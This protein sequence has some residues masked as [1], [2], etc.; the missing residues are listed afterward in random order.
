MNTKYFLILLWVM[1]LA[2]SVSAQ[3]TAFTYQG[4][5]TDG[6]AAASGTYDF[7]FK[8]YSTVN[9]G[10]ALGTVTVDDV[11]VTNGVFTVQLDFGATPFAN[12]AAQFLEICVRL[13]SQT[14]GYTTLTPRQRVN[15]TPYA[16]RSL[17]ANDAL[18]LNGVAASQYVQT[19]D[20]RLSDARPPTAGSAN[21]IQNTTTA[22]AASNFN[23]SGNGVAGGTLSGNVVNAA[24]QFNLNGGRVL[25]AD[26]NSN[27]AVGLESGLSG[28]NNTA[29]G[30]FAGKNNT[31]DGNAFLGYV[32][33]FRNTGND[34]AFFGAQA[35]LSNTSGQG[36]SFFGSFA[37]I[38][39]VTGNGNVFLGAGTGYANTASDNTFIG[40]DVGSFNTSGTGNAFLGRLTGFSNL[41]GNFN[42]LMGYRADTRTDGLT[43][44]AA[45]GA[46][47]RVDCSNCLVLGSVN[48]VNQATASVN[49][50]L[51]TSAPQAR[52]HVKHDSL[53]GNQW[54]LYLENAAQA[55][56]R[57][58]FRLS[59]SGALEVTSDALNANPNFA[60]LDSGGNWT[61][62]SDRRLKTAIRPLKGL[63][64]GA[65]QL[66][67][68]SFQ[69]LQQPQPHI[70]FIAQEVAAVF[71]T[72]VTTGE[73]N[74]LNYAGL[75][76]VA[77]GAVQ[78]QQEQ[79][80]KLQRQ[81]ATTQ[82]EN[83]ALRGLLNNLQTRLTQLERQAARPHGR[84]TPRAHR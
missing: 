63:L 35:G 19:N 14:G 3:D 72:L 33:G 23:I 37:G 74:T 4:R 41:T 43:N 26:S 71:P 49:V 46:R 54:G 22:Q 30:P 18:Q 13:G 77:I 8:L 68:V 5:L 31:G 29:V 11:D 36:N 51:G 17:L 34:N 38:S 47:A 69:Y 12:N 75:S 70:G 42:T 61:V 73:V 64:A 24:L 45:L 40:T 60:R 50:G 67:P 20:A 2:T 53:S 80:T 79:L 15:A 7:Q 10:S 84:R 78:E 28:A 16:L 83:D 25:G 81:L 6:S 39:N 9:G 82:A 21:Y 58:G 56:F 48:G 59:N 52:L 65:L 62:V 57:A 44:A 76:V 27:L 55:N 66:R 32:A 1:L